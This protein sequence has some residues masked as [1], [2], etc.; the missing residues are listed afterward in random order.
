MQA[1]YRAVHD[2]QTAVR[3]LKALSSAYGIDPTKISLIGQGSGGYVSQ[4][5]ATL[6]DYVTEIA[7]LEKFQDSETGFPYVIEARDGDIEGGPGFLRLIDPLFGAVPN[8]DI[9]MAVNMG[10][11]LADST[12]V[13]DG[14]VPMVAF[15]CLRDPYA[16]F[17][18]GV[19]VVPTTN[20]NVVEVSGGNVFIR[21]ANQF[22]NNDAF[23]SIPDGD[24]YTDAARATYGQTYDYI[25]ANEPTMTVSETPEGLYPFILPLNGDISVYGNQGAPWDWWDYNTLEVVV[26]ATNDVAGTDFNA[27]ELNASGLFSNPGMGPEKGLAYIDTIQGYLNPRVVL[28]CNLVTG[29]AE[30]VEVQ[31]AMSIFPNP[32]TTPVVI[33]NE[34]AEMSEIVIMDAIGREVQRVNVNGFTYTLNHDGWKSGMYFVTVLFKE[35]GQLTKKLIL[36]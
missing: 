9:C 16:P 26:D 8:K 13:N 2:T 18:N 22:G 4:A 6:D 31:N 27:A 33:S 3:Y 36:K 5:Y 24:V 19:V 20:E 28:A 35:G 14:D 7:E 15:H 12:W 34:K 11:S 10:G 32:A 25:Y 17:D 29:I 30:N 23:A 21:I 1:V